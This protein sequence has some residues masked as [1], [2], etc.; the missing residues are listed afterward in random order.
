VEFVRALF[1]VLM[2]DGALGSKG[3]TEGGRGQIVAAKSWWSLRVDC[4]A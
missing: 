4:P 3:I 2:R 1:F